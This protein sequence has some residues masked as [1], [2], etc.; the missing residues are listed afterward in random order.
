MKKIF[1]IL[2]SILSINVVKAFDI[3]IDKIEI[4]SRSKTLANDLDKSYKIDTGDFSHLIVNDE[5]AIKLVKSLINISTSN[6]DLDAK[7]KEY[8]SHMYTDPSDGA[9]TLA[10]TIFRDTY[11]NELKK[12]K[13]EG[14][15]ISDVK[16][17]PFDND[18]LAFAYIKDAKVNEKDNEVVLTYW[19][20]KNQGEYK[21][22]YPWVTVD[23]KL[24]DFFKKIAD[25]E[26]GGD[27]IGTAYNKLSLATGESIFVPDDELKSLYLNN[28]NKVVQITGMSENGMNMY[29]SGFFLRD[30]VIVTTWSL[31]QQFLTNS[32]YIYVNDVLGNTYKITGIVAAQ[33]DYDAV[34]LKLDKKVGTKVDFAKATELKLDDKLFMINSRNN[35][36]FSINY[37]T[38]VSIEKGRLKNL[39]AISSSD[40]GSALFNKEGK[41]VGFNVSDQTNS[42]LSYA[43]STDYLVSLQELLLKQDYE[44]IKAT[45]IEVFKD[46]YYLHLNKEKEYNNVSKKVWN[47]FKTIGNLEKNISLNLIK[48]SYNDHILSLRYKANSYGTLD[49][50]YM[51]ASFMEELEKENYNLV[52][53]T[54]SKRVYENSKYKVVIK[55]NFS[56]LIILIV[57]K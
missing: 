42:E 21:V 30:G 5:N 2:L 31:F 7:K 8:T 24:E 45:D 47:K 22:Y 53:D 28:K 29:G 25:A 27:F 15:Y 40:V 13:I 23:T 6:I 11:F 33:V 56:Y 1:V 36:G 41:V 43:N 54:N 12:Y 37:G 17:V 16:T 48:A 9:K 19:L 44:S 3:D 32:N 26:D 38:F 10:G 35:G 20:K 50:M 52:Q 18:V 4:N 51:A 49:S 57:E 55:E 46:S 34:V 14:G 39:L